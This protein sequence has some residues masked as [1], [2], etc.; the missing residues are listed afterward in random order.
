MS[1]TFGIVFLQPSR[2]NLVKPTNFLVPILKEIKD[3][4]E[5]EV[6]MFSV[7]Y[8]PADAYSSA[9]EVTKPGFPPNQ[10]RRAPLP[11]G[12]ETFE[13]KVY[14]KLQYEA[15]LLGEALI[16]LYRITKIAAEVI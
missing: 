1:K 15:K 11:D 13:V 10:V 5:N 7:K 3:M 6:K 14:A 4:E 8:W 2:D 12:E 9:C 16:R